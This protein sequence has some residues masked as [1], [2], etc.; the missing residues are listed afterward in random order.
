MS[1]YC[2]TTYGTPHKFALC[3]I[4]KEP[5][6]I[7]GAEDSV[8]QAITP[9]R[10]GKADS[11]P[12]IDHS[13][14]L[15]MLEQSGY[16]IGL[17][18]A[19]SKRA[20]DGATVDQRLHQSSEK[21]VA[22]MLPP[23]PPGT[24][25]GI[26]EYH[27]YH[28]NE[29]WHAVYSRTENKHLQDPANQFEDNRERQ[30][31]MRSFTDIMKDIETSVSQGVKKSGPME[32]RQTLDVVKR[33]THE[34]VQETVGN[35]NILQGRTSNLVSDGR[36]DQPRSKLVTPVQ[37]ESAL[38]IQRKLRERAAEENEKH[39]RILHKPPIP[40]RDDRYEAAVTDVTR[41]FQTKN[42]K[43]KE[44][45]AKGL[46]RRKGHQ[47]GS[48]L[49]DGQR[50]SNSRG[51]VGRFHGHNL[52]EA[53]AEKTLLADTEAGVANA[54]AAEA[55]QAAALENHNIYMSM[56]DGQ[57]S[58]RQMS[59]DSSAL[60]QERQSIDPKLAVPPRDYANDESHE[61][62][63]KRFT[64]AALEM[65]EDA[66]A[67]LMT[68]HHLSMDG[69][70]ASRVARAL[71]ESHRTDH[72]MEQ[73]DRAPG[74]IRTSIPSMTGVETEPVVEP[75]DHPFTSLPIVQPTGEGGNNLLPKFNEQ[76]L[77]QTAA[78]TNELV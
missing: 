75:T 3:R 1:S 56:S 10:A 11:P 16:T 69:S 32:L 37:N 33:P 74:A 78:A 76:Q 45:K 65:D 22:P 39:F 52:P 14:D 2:T 71:A 40:G 36:V 64:S 29:V 25:T 35:E 30:R 17:E 28:F 59:L 15:Q 62:H 51:D 70:D 19:A 61:S 12:E 68:S 41:W 6:A 43:E 47:G 57:H 20:V 54:T 8:L 60:Q 42:A 31:H 4:I 46:R 27:Y 24:L 23:P 44:A 38:G 63:V 67:S 13:M 50:E 48:A 34:K 66:F 21:T 49:A 72:G 9:A 7:A 77:Q 5:G 55:E 58:G 53:A 18:Y 73:P 26:T